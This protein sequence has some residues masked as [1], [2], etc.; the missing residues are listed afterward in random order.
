M[1]RK[2][3]KDLKKIFFFYFSAGEILDLSVQ[4]AFITFLSL[5]RFLPWY[6]VL[7]SFTC[8]FS[9][10]KFQCSQIVSEASPSRSLHEHSAG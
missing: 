8:V 3:D 7:Q 4:A 2:E 9:L 1:V 5:V 10:P 6:P